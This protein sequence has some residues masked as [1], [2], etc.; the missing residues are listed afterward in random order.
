VSRMSPIPIGSASW[1]PS[2]CL[3]SDSTST[4]QERRVTD[5]GP[6]VEKLYSGAGGDASFALLHTNQRLRSAAHPV[7]T[8]SGSPTRA[9]SSYEM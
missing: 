9:S 5:D 7:R 4:H 6:A 1:S 3:E 8:T 2:E